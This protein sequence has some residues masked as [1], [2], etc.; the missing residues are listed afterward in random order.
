V[1][2]ARLRRGSV[3]ILLIDRPVHKPLPAEGSGRETRSKPRKNGFM[4]HDG[5]RRGRP[6]ASRR[7][8]RRWTAGGSSREDHERACGPF[9]RC[10]RLCAVTAP[11]MKGGMSDAIAND[12]S[13]KEESVA[14]ERAFRARMPTSS[15]SR[16]AAQRPA[17]DPYGRL[18]APLAARHQ[19][20]FGFLHF[21]FARARLRGR[22]SVVSARS[23]HRQAEIQACLPLS[24]PRCRTCSRTGL[25]VPRD[26]RR[27]DCDVELPAWHQEGHPAHASWVFRRGEHQQ[28]QLGLHFVGMYPGS[29]RTARSGHLRQARYQDARGAL[30][31][32]LRD[33]DV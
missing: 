21:P 13:L 5:G 23:H 24:A 30:S 27:V 10:V 31:A 4:R 7:A 18:G 8:R 2:L 17:V 32:G 20:R 26:D 28:A 33:Q 14:A 11:S 25:R 12:P 15:G 29:S 6:L 3:N 19:V 22:R 16:S 1:A 9:T